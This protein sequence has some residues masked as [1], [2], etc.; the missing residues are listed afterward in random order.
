MTLKL[1]DADPLRAPNLMEEGQAGGRTADGQT[2]R[3]AVL[4]MLSF[5]TM[6]F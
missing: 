2:G 6:A 1:W 4:H 5:R 3:R